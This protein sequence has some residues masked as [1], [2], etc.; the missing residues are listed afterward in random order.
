MNIKLRGCVSNMEYKMLEAATGN[1]DESNV[2]GVGGFECV[3]K[4][5]LDGNFYV[6]VK[7]T[8]GGSQEAEK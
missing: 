7:K 5:K 8:N 6:A 1:F 2:V 3:D 4:A